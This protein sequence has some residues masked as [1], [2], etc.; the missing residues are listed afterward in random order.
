MPKSLKFTNHYQLHKIVIYFPTSCRVLPVPVFGLV[1]VEL[2]SP[3]DSGARSLF[4]CAES[5]SDFFLAKN[6]FKSVT[7]VPLTLTAN[8]T[9]VNWSMFGGLCRILGCCL[10]SL[11]V[12]VVLLLLEFVVLSPLV[13]VFVS[14]VVVFIPF[15]AVVLF[16]SLFVVTSG[17]L[18][19]VFVFVVLLSSCLCLFVVMYPVIDGCFLVVFG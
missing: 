19:V 16:S 10:L 7:F 4:A 13:V 1:N 11:V 12:V 8:F 15:V 5:R 18:F 2:F 17:L 14:V 6:S 9:G 3:L